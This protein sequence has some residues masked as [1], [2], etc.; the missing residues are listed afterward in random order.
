MAVDHFLKIEGIEGESEDQEHKGWIDLVSW[1]WGAMQSGT[2]SQGGGGGAGKVSMRDFHFTMRVCKASPKLLEACASGE[3][4]GSATLDRP[5]GGQDAAEVPQDQVLR[6]PR[7]LVRHGPAG[8]PLPIDSISLNF[9]K[10]EYEYSPQDAKGTLD[11]RDP[12]GLGPQEERQGLM[13][14]EPIPTEQNDGLP[15]GRP[16]LFR[17]G[18]RLARVPDASPAQLGSGS[19][20]SKSTG[21]SSKRL[22]SSSSTRKD[23]RP[24]PDWRSSERVFQSVIR[25]SFTRL[26]AWAE[27]PG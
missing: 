13:P 18:R 21:P 2:M 20:E 17:A 15:R 7:L 19:R 27:E 1:N 14:P 26:S 24:R 11:R 22:S 8:D 5:Q 25:P 3:H 16:F 23:R 10:I 9:A 6:P 4:F 12:R